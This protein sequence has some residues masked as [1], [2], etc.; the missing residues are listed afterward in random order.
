M[1]CTMP[2]YELVKHGSRVQSVSPGRHIRSP[3]RLSQRHQA[4]AM[5]CLLKIP[6]GV[7]VHHCQGIQKRPELGEAVGDGLESEESQVFEKNGFVVEMQEGHPTCLLFLL[8]HF[9]GWGRGQ[10]DSRCHAPGQW[11]NL[12]G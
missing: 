3:S 2:T 1:G 10:N 11:Q 7:H 12:Y 5:G 4:K 9:L 8:H 6:R